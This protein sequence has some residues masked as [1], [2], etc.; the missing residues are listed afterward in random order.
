A[1]SLTHSVHIGDALGIFANSSENSVI[2][3]TDLKAQ[4]SEYLASLF[5][6]YA[7]QEYVLFF[8]QQQNGPDRMWVINSRHSL[9]EVVNALR[10]SGLIPATIRQEKTQTEVLFVDFA[11]RATDRVKALASAVDGSTSVAVGVAALPGN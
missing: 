9:A 4:F 6:R 8:V 11:S 5:G 10:K 2:I 3:E 1:C 7:H